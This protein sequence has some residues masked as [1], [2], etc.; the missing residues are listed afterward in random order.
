MRTPMGAKPI[1]LSSLQPREQQKEK[2]PTVPASGNQRPSVDMSAL[3]KALA[4]ALQ[5]RDAPVS[6]VPRASPVKEKKEER[7]VNPGEAV[8]F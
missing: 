4:E 7:V 2:S 6:P 8:K 5:E 1:S 3:K